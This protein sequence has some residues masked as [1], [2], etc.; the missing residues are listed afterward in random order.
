MKV[1]EKMG[2]WAML[3]SAHLLENCGE[4]LSGSHD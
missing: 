3:E 1:V 4:V 2:L